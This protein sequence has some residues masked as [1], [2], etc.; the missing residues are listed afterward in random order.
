VLAGPE[1]HHLIHVMRA[2]PG[3]RVVL[4]DG[5]GVEFAAE[6]CDVRRSEVTLAV[7]DRTQVDRELPLRLVL[8]VALPK[9]DRQKWLIEKAVELGVSQVVPLE[10]AR[11]V[12]QPVEQAL[13][14]LRRTVIEASK[15]CG[16]NRLMELSLPRTWAQLIRGTA[17]I[18]LRL[19]AHPGGQGDSSLIR[20]PQAGGHPSSFPS[21][22]VAIGPEGGFSPDELRAALEA[23]WQQVVLGT[24]ILRVETA[25]IFLVASVIQGL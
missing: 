22:V 25:A 21:M 2:K 11:S 7:L 6:V 15:Q 8:A 18:P 9:G 23:G 14:R 24:R 4:F 17:D 16:R 3:M 19:L 20:D 1:A 10:T 13:Q 12:A 5:S